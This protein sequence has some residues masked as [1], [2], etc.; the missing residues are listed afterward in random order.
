VAPEG[1][2]TVADIM[3]HPVVTATAD[4][5]VSAAAQRMREDSVGSVVVVDGEQAIGILTERDL[6][7][8]AGAGGGRQPGE[9]GRNLGFVGF[10]VDAHDP[11]AS[12]GVI[13]HDA[14]KRRH[15]PAVRPHHPV[16]RHL[17]P[18]SS[19]RQHHPVLSDGRSERGR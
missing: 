15:T 7:R 10:V 5:T 18:E 16:E 13:A 8:H 3:S 2:R 4:E 6:V 14:E 1:K 11:R 17:V 12:L 19:R 9:P